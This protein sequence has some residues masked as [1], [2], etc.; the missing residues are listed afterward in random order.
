MKT[1]KVILNSLLIFMLG[2]SVMVGCGKE[3]KRISGQDYVAVE[4]IPDENGNVSTESTNNDMAGESGETEDISNTETDNS[5]SAKKNYFEEKGLVCTA[6]TAFTSDAAFFFVNSDRSEI[7]DNII[8]SFGDAKCKLS[9]GE[10]SV[11]EGVNGSADIKIVIN[12]QLETTVEESPESDGNAEFDFGVNFMN[13]YLADKYT[14]YILLGKSNVDNAV[15][16]NQTSFTVDGRNISLD[17]SDNMIW[18]NVETTEWAEPSETSG[19][20]TELTWPFIRTITI[21]APKEYNGAVLVL[22]KNGTTTPSLL[23]SDI[24]GKLILDAEYD[25]QIL[26]K[27]DF[28]YIDISTIAK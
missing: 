10:C 7:T 14:G 15:N 13:F 19:Y 23:S 25:G 6:D 11:T 26:N 4:P 20:T 16:N 3:D 21:N 1:R 22:P 8:F 27:E 2:L 18:Q 9:I 24:T 17:L 28:Y 12:G 5:H